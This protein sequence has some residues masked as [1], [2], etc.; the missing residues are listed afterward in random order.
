M[1]RVSKEQIEA[2]RK[3]GVLEYFQI[4]MPH[5][6][7]KVSCHDFRTKTHSS[8]IISDNGLFHWYSAG[9]GGNNAIDYLLK[10]EKMDFVSAVRLLNEIAPVRSSFQSVSPLS[11]SPK[12]SKVFTP[13]ERDQSVDTVQSYLYR[14][15]ISG[16]VFRFCCNSGIVYQTTRGGYKNC[17]FLGLDENGIP[18]SAFTRSCQGTW[19]G[20]ISGSQKKY[21]F[22]I[23]AESE[24]CSSVSIFE[25]PIDAMSAA[26][27]VQYERQ[28]PWRSQFYLSMGGMNQQSINYFLETHPNV[29][30][31]SLCLDN[32]V[33]GR[34]FSKRL[35][36][37]LINEGY[38]VVDTPPKIGK[39][40]NE[41]LLFLKQKL[42]QSPTR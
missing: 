21:G 15:G 22:L 8:L 9:V 19:R 14:R 5:E 6:L 11:P 27:L 25:A 12:I 16:K 36:E 1:H 17:V 32:D 29:K 10:V 41:Q 39:D 38:N 31:I 26:S 37:M 18:R 34:N 4:R 20:D 13:P 33:P 42:S 24:H 40:Y 23:P 35:Q 30:N 28:Q 2:A 3:V 7:V